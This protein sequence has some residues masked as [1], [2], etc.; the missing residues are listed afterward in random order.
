MPCAEN[1]R[2]AYRGLKIF[3]SLDSDNPDHLPLDR[4]RLCYNLFMS[5]KQIKKY[6]QKNPKRAKIIKKAVSKGVKQYE[7]TFRRL[8]AA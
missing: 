7:E 4:L 5:E 6:E 3:S 8:A 1:I 2:L